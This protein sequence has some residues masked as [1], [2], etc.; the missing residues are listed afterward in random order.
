MQQEAL[1]ADDLDAGRLRALLAVL[2][3]ETHFRAH[4]QPLE[5]AVQ[6]AVP[7][8]VDLPV[9]VHGAQEAVTLVEEL[10]TMPCG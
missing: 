6:D 10:S 7:M 8:E 2:R 1:A 3:G 5:V 9:V 4:R